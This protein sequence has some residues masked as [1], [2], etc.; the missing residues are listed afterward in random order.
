ME[1]PTECV[2]CGKQETR[3]HILYGC[4]HWFQWDPGGLSKSDMLSDDNMTRV[5]AVHEFLQ[6][7]RYA[8]SFS[9]KDIWEA[10]NDPDGGEEKDLA[11][12]IMD[13]HT[14]DRVRKWE[15]AQQTIRD[16]RRRADH[17]VYF[18]HSDLLHLEADFTRVKKT[19]GEEY[20]KQYSHIM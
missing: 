13:L 17:D 18:R 19:L 1:G 6:L 7:N 20:V 2:L 4:P 8:F 10:Y 3:E 5:Y 11:E 15:L 9:L 16:G 14:W 12:E